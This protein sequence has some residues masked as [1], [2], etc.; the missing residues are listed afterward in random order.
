MAIKSHS[1]LAYAIHEASHAVV[2]HLCGFK[3]TFLYIALERSRGKCEIDRGFNPD[4]AC[5]FVRRSP[6]DPQTAELL[7]RL[8]R[9]L[10]GR[11]A[12]MVGDA[13]HGIEGSA[14]EYKLD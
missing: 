5:L 13:M 12:G 3:I 7:P 6:N 4:D 1:A 11:L 2:G 8:K 10:A 9:D 14:A